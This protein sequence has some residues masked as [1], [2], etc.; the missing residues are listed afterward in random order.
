MKKIGV[1]MAA[2]LFAATS[3]SGCQTTGESAG[4]GAVVGAIAGAIIG[5]QSGRAWEGA[6][7]GGAIGALAG[8]IAHDVKQRQ[9]KTAEETYAENSFEPA[10]DPFTITIKEAEAAPLAVTPGTELNTEFQYAVMGAPGNV[11]VQERTV[12]QMA[13]REKEIHNTSISRGDGSYF[14]EMKIPMPAK[15]PAS[16]CVIKHTVSANGKD[17]VRTLNLKIVEARLDDGTIER[18]FQVAS[19]DAD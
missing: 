19:V 12:F 10:T 16:D 18:R 6:A 11:T 1:F 17:D 8:L 7:I 4:T 9:M 5:N 13:G 2:A 14:T 15:A 3:F